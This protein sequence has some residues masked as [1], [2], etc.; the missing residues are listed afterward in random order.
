MIE[1]LG[2]LFN[3]LAS[4]MT[5]Q[6]IAVCILGSVLGFV[7]GALPGLGC[8]AGVSLMLPLAF[9]LNPVAGIAMLGSIYYATMYGGAFS[10]ILL[11]IPGDA[12]AV[13]TSLDGY[14]MARKGRPGQALFAAIIS[15]CIGGIIGMLILTMFGPILAEWGLKFGPTE[16]AAL[17]L[18]ALSSIGWLMGDDP[19]KGI[20]S[21]MFGLLIG[22]IGLDIY[23]TPR[24]TF[25]V[26]HLLGGLPFAAVGIGLFGF[27]QV[28][29]MIEQRGQEIKTEVDASHLTIKGSL[30]SKEE[31]K[32]ILPPALRSSFL[33]TMIGILPG[34]GATCSAF[35]CYAMQKFFHKKNREPM[36]SGAIEGVAASE[37]ANNSA[38]AGA[39]APLLALGIPGSAVTAILLSALQVWGLKPGPLLFTNSPDFAWSTIASL[40]LSNLLTLVVAIVAIPFI[41][42][43]L[44]VPVKFM[45]P[46]VTF[47]CMI[48]AYSINNS[49]YGV[50]VMLISGLVGYIL[51][52]YKFPTSPVLLA[53]VL[54][55][56]FEENVRKALITSQG[57][58]GIF[59]SRPISLVILLIL[60]VLLVVP[61]IKS[62][63]RKAKAPG[64]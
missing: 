58:I 36:G 2:S 31:V 3:G 29:G 53:F 57:K 18:L 55:T 56:L 43:I 46:C 42:K 30:P 50:W 59:F 11:N 17:M 14:P 19:V 38:C 6:N 47:I 22:Y 41:I 23:G 44:K 63:V 15:S 27:S 40:F 20:I 33:G 1:N 34:A 35:L 25:G 21:A 8:I 10:A 39:F 13:M 62:I 48:G 54:S 51:N 16:M 37:A 4:L 12:P 52:K 60:A 64:K 9:S 7:V 61:L 49:M 28:L 26:M 45:I 5:L 24:Y 32:R